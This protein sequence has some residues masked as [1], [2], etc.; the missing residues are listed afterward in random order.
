MNMNSRNG[1]GLLSDEAYS[2]I[3]EMIVT[4]VLQPGQMI[5]ENALRESLGCGRTPVREALQRLQFE[6]F[7]D[8]HPRRG[9]LVTSIDI[10]KQLELLE[11]RRPLETLV[12][13]LAAQRAT[14]DQRLEMQQ[15]ADRLDDAVQREDRKQYLAINRAIHELEVAA[16][17][18]SQLQFTMGQIHKLSRRFWYN[19][20]SDTESFSEAAVL[21]SAV[22]RSIAGHDADNAGRSAGKLMD[23]LE[24]VTRQAIDQLSNG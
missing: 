6:G 22:L 21:H 15:L 17:G 9:A 16:T 4:N 23:L 2:Q 14:S 7:V 10:R 11:V 24:R 13:R 1:S 18:N 20:I 8:I 5:S 3:Q 19:F 12:V